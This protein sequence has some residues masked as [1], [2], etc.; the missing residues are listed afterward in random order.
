MPCPRADLSACPS[1]G[2]VRLAALPLRI[3]HMTLL[4]ESEFKK[5]KH[6]TPRACTT[7]MTL[8]TA[9][10]RVCAQAFLRMPNFSKSKNPIRQAAAL[11]R[12]EKHRRTRASAGATAFDSAV[13]G[14]CESSERLMRKA[15][16][17]AHRRSVRTADR[18]TAVL[19]ESA[20]CDGAACFWRRSLSRCA[21]SRAS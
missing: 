16:R 19:W 7:I 15:R 21:P 2:A 6:C 12:E 14:R 5:H 9:L 18:A 13:A 17:R 3:A 10:L 8:N 4:Y 1:S 20:A 11:A